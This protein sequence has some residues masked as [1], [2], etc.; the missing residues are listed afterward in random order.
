VLRAVQLNKPLIK[1]N[2]V[3]GRS[4]PLIDAISPRY[5][6]RVMRVTGVARF[7]RDQAKINSER[8]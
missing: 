7:L 6:D 4:G 1:V 5:Y 3:L 2:K 8:E